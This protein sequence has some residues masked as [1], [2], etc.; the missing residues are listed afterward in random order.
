M[1][2][3]RIEKD[4]RR[5]QEKYAVFGVNTN[6]ALEKLGAFP[7]SLNCWQGDDVGGFEH[8]DSTLSGG[9]LQVTGNY[10]G[11]ARSV[12]ELRTD[13]EMAFSLIPGT[14]RLNLHAIYGEFGDSG[15][16]RDEISTQH[17]Q[18]WI[19]WAI[20]NRLGL[21]FNATLFSHPKADSGFTLSSK[22]KNIRRFW[23]KHVQLCREIAVY[24]GKELGQ[25]CLHNLWIPD[26]AKDITVDRF[27]YRRILK[28]SLDEIYNQKH[29][30]D[31]LKDSVESKLFGI[32]SEAFV[33]GSHEFYLSY[34]LTR[35]L[36]P[37]F[38]MGHF[39]PTETV[40]DKISSVL[41]FS[42][43]LLLHVS[44]GLRWDSD[45]VVIF[46]DN[47]LD[48]M[49]EVVRSGVMNRI[50]VSLDF[51]DASMNRVGAWVIGAR[52]TLKGLLAALLEPRERLLEAEISGDYFTRLALLEEAKTLPLASVW[53]F[54]C[55]K[56][57]V[58]SG[59]GWIDEIQEYDREVS[60]KRQ[61]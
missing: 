56:S 36:L 35:G 53:D 39:H 37:C 43:E 4:Y 38:D 59:D 55:L 15:V 9:G 10:P 41:Q 29:P 3:A 8:P 20:V 30:E 46:D 54:F 2:S 33:V 57:G 16:D 19:D 28:D 44:R 12:D 27:T 14:H 22:E 34:A 18:G 11:K 31:R 25:T 21:D 58:P 42:N 23:I 26:G 52:A 6:Q 50:H 5:A 17:F 24:M 48:L 32:G 45:H 51:F 61:D 49:S 13:L 1:E 60:R 40:A 47:L 7:L